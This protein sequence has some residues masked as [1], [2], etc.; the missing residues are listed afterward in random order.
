MGPRDQEASHQAR[1]RVQA[2]RSGG[3]QA[4]RSG[5]TVF[6]QHPKTTTAAS[7]PK[8]SPG[9]GLGEGMSVKSV[10]SGFRPAATRRSAAGL[11]LTARP[12]ERLPL[13]F[14]VSL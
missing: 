12:L 9:H 14:L 1:I 2:K 4:N 10:L 8:P 3:H 13:G 6:E 11:G 5:A 7:F